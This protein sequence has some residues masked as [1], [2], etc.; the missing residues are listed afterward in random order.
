MTGTMPIPDGSVIITPTQM[1]QQIGELAIAV[2]DL[3]S[4]VD[5]A[6]TDVRHDVADHESRIRVIEGRKYVSP[7][8]LAWFAGFAVTCLGVLITFLALTHGGAQ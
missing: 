3:K 6:I 1:Y 4:V 5:P 8:A 2:R 7:V